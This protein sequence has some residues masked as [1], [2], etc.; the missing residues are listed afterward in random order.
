MTQ[1]EK[2]LAAKPQYLSLI[3]VINI[4]EEEN[5]FPQVVCDL[6][7]KHATAYVQP[8]TLNKCKNNSI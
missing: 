1:Q 8:P 6:H 2:M 7:H 3:P 4:V 5:L